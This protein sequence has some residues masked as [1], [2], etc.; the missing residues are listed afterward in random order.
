MEL[1]KHVLSRYL[2]GIRTLTSNLID[3][4]FLSHNYRYQYLASNLQDASDNL[5][6]C[7]VLELREASQ[8]LHS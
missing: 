3:K 4:S 2:I 7:S 5:K 8:P 1:Y 6:P